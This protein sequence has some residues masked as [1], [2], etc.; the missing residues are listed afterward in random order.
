MAKRTK[1]TDEMIAAEAAKYETRGAFAK[2][3]KNAYYAARARGILD[4]VCAHMKNGRIGRIKWT[5]EML[6][7]EAA[8]YKARGAFKEGNASAYAIALARGILDD[9][10]AHMKSPYIHWTDEMLAVEASKYETRSAFKKENAK[11]YSVARTRGILDDI[12]AH[13]KN[14]YLLWTDEM[15]AVEA[16]KYK[17]RIAFK[18]GS[19]GAYQ[20][21]CTRGI[22]D[23]VCTHME[24]L[25]TDWTDEVLAAEAA[26]YETRGAFKEGN[27]N[28]YG[29]A[30]RRGILDSICAQMESGLGSGDNDTVYM[31]RAANEWFNGKPVYKIGVTSWRL[32]DKRIQQVARDSGFHPNL[33]FRIQVAPG[34][35]T[36]IEAELLATFGE[37]VNYEK[38]NG[39]SEFRAFTVDEAVEIGN[40]VKAH[41]V[42]D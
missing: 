12:C 23:D 37:Q 30:I 39:S 41:E 14:G 40:L 8:K 5:D 16:K 26:K 35:A 22:L 1:W 25:L 9:I 13:M 38:F 21:A 31:W 17:T 32:G 19:H 3:S 36:E 20:A 29:A 34:T 10:C 18:N 4:V 15:I 2:G 28:A 33:C 11:A 7:T 24:T 27:P 42:I 6:A